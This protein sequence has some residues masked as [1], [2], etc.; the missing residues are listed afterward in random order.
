VYRNLEHKILLLFK[1]R[2]HLIISG[3]NSDCIRLLRYQATRIKDPGWN[4]TLFGRQPQAIP[5]S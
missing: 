3:Q 4:I 1:I 2:Q 5:V